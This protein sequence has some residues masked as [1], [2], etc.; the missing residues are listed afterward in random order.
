MFAN[1]LIGLREGL[2]AALIVSILLAYVVRI[3]RRELMR[4]IWIGVALATAA[5]IGAGALLQA[6]STSLDEESQEVFAGAM[7]LLAVV[8]ITWMV[9][10]MAKR[11]RHLRAELERSVDRALVGGAATLAVTSFVAVIREGLETAL[12]LWTGVTSTS[13]GEAASSL[14]GAILGLATAVALGIGLYQGA[15]RLDLR[16][17]FRWSGV[18][19][20]IVAAGML[21]YAV[22]EF[23]AVGWLP[24]ADVVAYDISSVLPEDSALAALLRGLLNFRPSASWMMVGAWWLYVLPTLTLFLSRSK[25]R[26]TAPAAA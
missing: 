8:L 9:F 15:V 16:T 2:E 25:P 14:S 11:A 4:P 10:W 13:V 19:L 20:V 12:F 26:I 22:K 3:G 7:S 23:Q 5:S 17:L 24:G 6:T 21:T 1:Y 18:A